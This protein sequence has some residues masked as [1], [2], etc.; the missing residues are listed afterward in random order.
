MKYFDIQELGRTIKTNC[1]YVL[2]AYLFGSSQRGV[3]KR[4]SD[5]DIAVYI[6]DKSK[7]A[8][9]I[10]K[11]VE[12]IEPICDEVPVDVT[13]LN[14]ASP[15]LAFEVLNGKKL[16]AKENGIDTHAE[17]YS[18]TCREFESEN[19]W[20]QQQLKYRNYEVQWSH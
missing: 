3:I 7:K 10:L 4:S 5:I 18:I 14:D 16:F 12:L 8:E 20:M 19:F 11:I 2:F 17:F 6:S 9:T 15:I 1:P 13:I